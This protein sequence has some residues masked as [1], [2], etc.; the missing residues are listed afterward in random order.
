MGTVGEI[1]ES[2]AGT[3]LSCLPV[4]L[5]AKGLVQPDSMTRPMLQTTSRQEILNES[6]YAG[7]FW[8]GIIA[9]RLVTSA[10]LSV[11][12]SGGVG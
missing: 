12:G 1:D 2:N 11:T 5:L 6:V 3:S 10:D 9:R 8:W 4:L 7:N